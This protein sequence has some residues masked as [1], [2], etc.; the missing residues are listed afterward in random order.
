M[1]AD[2]TH[3]YPRPPISLIESNLPGWGIDLYISGSDG[4]ADPQLLASHAIRIVL[5]CA[6]NLDL[7]IVSEAKTGV[8]E[9][10]MTHGTGL[11]R[12][13][14]L[15]LVDGPG[16]PDVMMLAGY[17]LLRSALDQ[18]FPDK[19]SY[20]RREKGNILVNC[21]GGRSRSVTLVSLFL[22]LDFP[23][24]YP[25]LDAA[26]AH[27]RVQRQLHPDEW[28]SA[29]KAVLVES[30]RRAADMVKLLKTAGFGLENVQ[31]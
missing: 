11:V 2:K 25:T 6:V 23:D 3:H 15:G 9:H 29:P 10:L 21:R 5:N 24:R 14:K 13:Y 22:H 4:A 16:N 18:Q 19:P 31:I 12:Y 8:A 26:I 17:H 7:D 20:P 28:Q 27:V 30:A 1:C